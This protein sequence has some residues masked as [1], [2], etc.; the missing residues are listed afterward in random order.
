M[1]QPQAL[2]FNLDMSHD[3]QQVGQTF[4]KVNQVETPALAKQESCRSEKVYQAAILFVPC[5]GP[6]IKEG[7]TT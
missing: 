3:R 7:L 5:M 2:G 4:S 6:L 1:N